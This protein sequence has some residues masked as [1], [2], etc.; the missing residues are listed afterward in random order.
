MT[1]A[2]TWFW[3]VRGHLSEGREWLRGVLALSS[4]SAADRARTYYWQARFAFWQGDYDAARER[5]EAGIA[6]YRA[7]D[8][9]PGAG[10]APNPPGPIHPHAGG[11]GR[12]TPGPGEGLA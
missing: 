10:G 12:A 9:R 4:L 5:V 11:A 6:A 8:D 1:L 2:L 3:L 7:L